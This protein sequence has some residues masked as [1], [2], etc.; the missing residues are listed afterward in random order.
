MIKLNN[1][2]GD[3]DVEKAVLSEINSY[4]A[5]EIPIMFFDQKLEMH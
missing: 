2:K 5:K 3:Q 1:E 4:I